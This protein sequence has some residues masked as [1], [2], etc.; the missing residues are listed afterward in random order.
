ML[1]IAHT[2]LIFVYFVY[3]IYTTCS[4]FIFLMRNVDEIE[5][6]ME[7]FDNMEEYG[8]QQNKHY[9]AIDSVSVSFFLN[10]SNKK[11]VV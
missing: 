2:F 8:I 5:T 6:M 4:A 9:K 7:N 3:N 1:I 10:I 11:N